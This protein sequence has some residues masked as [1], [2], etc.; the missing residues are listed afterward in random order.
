MPNRMV[1]IFDLHFKATQ[2]FGQKVVNS[3]KNNKKDKTKN[4]HEDWHKKVN[5]ANDSDFSVTKD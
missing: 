2:T 5:E 4:P 1:N 3:C